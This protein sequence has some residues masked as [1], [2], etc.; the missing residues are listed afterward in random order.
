MSKDT[1]CPACNANNHAVA[2]QA[3]AEGKLL[4]NKLSK[5]KYNCVLDEWVEKNEVTILRCFQCGHHW[6]DRKP[7][8]S[9]LFDMYDSLALNN[10]CNKPNVNGAR[11]HPNIGNIVKNLLQ[12]VSNKKVPHPRLLD[13]GAGSG[14]WANEFV[15]QGFNVVAYEPSKV[16]SGTSASG[17]EI[18]NEFNSLEGREFDVINMEQVLEHVPDPAFVLEQLRKFCVKDTV[19]RI[20]V[21][22]ISEESN[23]SNFWEGWPYANTKLHVMSPFEHLHGFTAKSLESLILQAGYKKL[24]GFEV[25]RTHPIYSIR[26]KVKFLLP[27]FGQTTLLIRLSDSDMSVSQNKVKS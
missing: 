27:Q 11:K 7:D 19:V 20:S 24:S 18:C 5:E 26:D 13:F 2:I 25:W 8:E 4:L 1:L 17:Y 16:R 22:N 9:I 6:Y 10:S 21:P 14:K 23:N 3:D 12:L 15:E